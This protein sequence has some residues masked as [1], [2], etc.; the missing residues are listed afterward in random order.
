MIKK[1]KISF[2]PV[3]NKKLNDPKTSPGVSKSKKELAIEKAINL[4]DTISIVYKDKEGNVTKRTVKPLRF[5]SYGR[6]KYVN[7]FCWLRNGERN[8]YLS[9]I[10][11][12][13]N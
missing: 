1:N 13:E 9:Q 3:V 5:D 7:A 10:G 4:G 6:R 2:N 8:F 11:N 12:I